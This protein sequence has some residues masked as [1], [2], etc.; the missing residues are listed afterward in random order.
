MTMMEIQPSKTKEL[1]FRHEQKYLISEDE[2]ACIV[3]VLKKIA[4]SDE[5]AKNG[6]YFIRS[7]YFDDLWESAWYD[8]LAGTA[9][10]KKYRIRFYNEIWNTKEPR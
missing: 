1:R 6:R 4:S 3:P 7:L 9:D 5:N 10:R 8:K 2:M